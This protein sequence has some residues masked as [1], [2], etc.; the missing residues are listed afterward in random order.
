MK[1]ISFVIFLLSF[2]LGVNFA[3][4]QNSIPSNPAPSWSGDELITDRPD[5]T[6]SSSTVP[7]KTLQIET[8]F[9]LENFSYDNI[10]FQNLG[11]GTTLLRYGVWDNFELR[12]GSY[13]QQSKVKSN[14]LDID[15]TQSGMGPILAGFKVYVIEEKGIRPEISILADLTL[16]KVGK[17][18]Y[19]PT[20]TY[21]TI[22][23][24][25]SHTLSDFFSL[26]YNLGFAS[27]GENANGLFVYSLVL[28][29]S[30][31]D[32]FG[33]FAEIYGTSAEGDDPHTRADAGFTYL[34]RPN[35]QLDISGG[36]GLDGEVNMYFVST[37]ITW[38]I[39]R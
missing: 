3:Q 18:D 27:D 29:M 13:Y 30:I 20:Y 31:T 32:K 11:L 23:I 38:R 12:L 4:E 25:A 28:G 17:L 10:E 14:D 9:V 35:L 16:N 36:T 2:N 5:Q 6:E 22:K 7:Q 39:P 24:S 8:G 37:G 19:R 34:L 21:S 15:S 1:Q 33:G 26:G